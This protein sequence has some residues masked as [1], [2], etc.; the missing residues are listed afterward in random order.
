M[1]SAS[2][3]A[4]TASGMI[5]HGYGATPEDHWF[6]WLA[7]RLN[8]AG[9]PAHV[10]ALPDPAAPDP[11]RWAAASAEALGQPGSGSIV[12]AHSLGCITALRHLSSLSEPWR[13]GALVLVAGFVDKL[14]ALP[15]LD[16]FIEKGV[17]LAGIRERVGSLTIIRSDEDPYVPIGHT[18]RLARLLDTSPVVVPG[19]GH[20]LAAD[21]VTSLPLVLEAIV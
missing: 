18:D 1:R 6:S 14:P 16:G 8:R 3:A 11:S 5:F 13:V 21:G 10:P 4:S 12:I 7:D 2:W 9:V 19:A 20:F 15:E 17:N